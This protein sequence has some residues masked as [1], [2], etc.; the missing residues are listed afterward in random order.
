MRSSDPLRSAGTPPRFI[1]ALAEVVRGEFLNMPGLCLTEAEACRLWNVE[2]L[3]CAAILQALV[4]T[5]FLVK[6]STGMYCTRRTLHFLNS[7]AN[8]ALGPLA[9]IVALAGIMAAWLIVDAL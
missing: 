7:D 3:V 5:E 1:A 4:D 2:P 8:Y 9:I 6:T